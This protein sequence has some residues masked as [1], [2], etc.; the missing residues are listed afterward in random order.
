MNLP[1]IDLNVPAAQ[2]DE[3]GE[4]SYQKNQA[5]SQTLKTQEVRGDIAGSQ[6]NTALKEAAKTEATRQAQEIHQLQTLDNYYL[7]EMRKNMNLTGGNE[8]AQFAA[9]YP[10]A[11]RALLK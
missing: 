5:I 9:Q 2:L 8:L 10:D 11:L 7:A 3:L 4:S 6:T 1:P